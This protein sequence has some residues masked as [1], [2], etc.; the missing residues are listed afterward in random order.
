MVELDTHRLGPQIQMRL[1][2][3]TGRRTVPNIMVNGKSIGGGDE[4]SE[5]D[6]SK[7]LVEK[8]RSL[9]GK[10]VTIKER[11]TQRPN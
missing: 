6:K 5:L 3:M 7:T 9:G 1:A 10:W 4:I 11:F 8:V 2:D